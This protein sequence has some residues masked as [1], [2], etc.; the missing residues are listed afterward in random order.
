MELRLQRCVQIVDSAPQQDPKCLPPRHLL[1][2]QQWTDPGYPC[3]GLPALVP[4][5]MQ[6]GLAPLDLQ[7]GDLL[8]ELTVNRLQLRPSGRLGDLFKYKPS[9]VCVFRRPRSTLPR[10]PAQAAKRP[11]PAH[12]KNR[13][14]IQ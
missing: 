10:P 11:A 9:L 6:P 14:A 8:I 4:S 1:C 7:A 5:L 12:L 2:R 13:S 3:A